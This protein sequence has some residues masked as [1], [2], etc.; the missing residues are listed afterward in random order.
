MNKKIAETKVAL[1]VLKEQYA[2]KIDSVKDKS[3]ITIAAFEAQENTLK[4][5]I[6]QIE[7]ELGLLALKRKEIPS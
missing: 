4:W 1:N 7:M 2:T 6:K 3:D 5:D